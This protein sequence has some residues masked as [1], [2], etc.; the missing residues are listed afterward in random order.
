MWESLH[1][2][3]YTIWTTGTL[4][5][6]AFA[7][8]HCTGGDILIGLSVLSLSLFLVGAREWP[9]ASYA[10]VRILT[11]GFGVTYTIFSEWLNIV[12]RA[13]WAYSELMPV[14]P[15]L[16]T[17]LSPLLQWVVVPALALHLARR[18]A[19]V[20]HVDFRRWKIM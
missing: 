3:L 14:L 1:L 16:Q 20:Q 2:P 18:F 11:I 4:R 10:R 17:G 15:L 13:A 6:K 19:C 8:L 5:E 7:V 12:V 9:A